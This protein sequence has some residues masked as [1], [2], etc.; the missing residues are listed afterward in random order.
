VTSLNRSE[1]AWSALQPVRSKLFDVV[2][3]LWTALFAPAALVLALCG[4]PERAVRK[5]ARTW[6]RGTLRLLGWCVGLKHVELGRE[7]IPSEPCL[8][9]ANHQSTWET[10]A[11]LA[12]FP[13]VA[14]VAKREL[15][16]IPVFAW[17]LRNSPMILIDR[18]SSKAVRKMVDE[19]R[20]ALANG[21]SVLIFPEGT[22]QSVSVPITFKRGI[23]ILYAKL[24]RKVLPV[25]LNS[26]HFWAPDQPYK[27]SGMIT[28]SYLGAIEPGL[29]GAEFTRQSQTVLEHARRNAFG[30]VK[31]HLGGTSLLQFSANAAQRPFTQVRTG[32][33]SEGKVAAYKASGHASN[34]RPG[35]RRD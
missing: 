6:A 33:R 3:V 9:I 24:G 26:G 30:E 13:D 14:I 1:A 12:L 2:L 29:T 35:R 16:T 32:L 21:R 7:N 11:F 8:I 17:F 19:S 28:V 25:A 27:R 23:E 15:L 20:A 18:E 10:L 31:R 5:T 34:A 22:R 4:T